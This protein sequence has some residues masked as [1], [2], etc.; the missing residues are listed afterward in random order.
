MD[1]YGGWYEDFWRLSSERQFGFG[2]G[3]IPQSAIDR[4][5]AG[6]SYDDVEVFEFCIREMDGLYMRTQNKS[7]DNPPTAASAMEAFRGATTN[8]RGK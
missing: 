5:V 6:W 7:G 1:G 3:P 2:L 8:R 4:H